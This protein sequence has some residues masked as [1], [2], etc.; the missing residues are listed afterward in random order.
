MGKVSVAAEDTAC[1]NKQMTF[2]VFS[3]NQMEKLCLSIKIHSIIMIFQAKK[4]LLNQSYTG[5]NPKFQAKTLQSVPLA[6]QKGKLNLLI[7]QFRL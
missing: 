6:N 3:Q 1:L 4:V 5:A 7:A 2:A